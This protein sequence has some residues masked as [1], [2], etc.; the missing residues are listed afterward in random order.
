MFPH[1]NLFHFLPGSVQNRRSKIMLKSEL[2]NCKQTPLHWT[3]LE[4][5]FCRGCGGSI[6]SKSHSCALELRYSFTSRN[7]FMLWARSGFASTSSLSVKTGDYYCLS[8]SLFCFP[9]RFICVLLLDRVCLEDSLIG[10]D[11]Q[12]MLKPNKFYYRTLSKSEL[13]GLFGSCLIGRL[14]ISYVS[15]NSQDLIFLQ[16]YFICSQE[17]EILEWAKWDTPS[18]TD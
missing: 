15:L 4:V 5:F 11:S 2:P 6:A 14:D 1:F 17:L 18:E 12:H 8:P 16:S 3:C 10:D 9:P 13:G 7:A